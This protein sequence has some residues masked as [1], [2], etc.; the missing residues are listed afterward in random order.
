[1]NFH[2]PFLGE[3]GALASALIWAFAVVLFKKSGETMPPLALNLFKSLLGASLILL[4]MLLLDISLIPGIPKNQFWLFF[5]SGVLG[6]G[7]SDTLF[8]MSLNRVGAG[9]SAIIDCLYSP[10]IIGFSIIWLNES[11]SVYQVVG[12]LMVIGG[13]L[14]TTGIK[15]SSE[16]NRKDLIWGIIFGVLAMATVGAGIVLIK[17]I[18]NNASIL[19]ISEIRLLGGILS[20]IIVIISLPQGR[21]IWASFKTHNHWKYTF[22]GA[23][24]GTYVA[25]ICWLIGMKF[26]NVSIAAALNQT[27]NLF[28]FIL[29]WLI[30]KESMNLLKIIGI[31]LGVSGVYIILNG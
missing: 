9:L 2:L 6:I 19:W 13:V 28:V 15:K 10:F 16:L 31:I 20:T 21:A 14:T 30:L 12:V 4:T 26:T 8:F 29:A 5:I 7:I 24:L 25:M 18:L 17:P 27:S 1:M 3:I 23:F 11:L 22:S